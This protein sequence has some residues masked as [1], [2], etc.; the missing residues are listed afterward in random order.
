MIRT[1]QLTTFNLISYVCWLSDLMMQLVL[2]KR[3]ETIH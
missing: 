1:A 2:T 3:K